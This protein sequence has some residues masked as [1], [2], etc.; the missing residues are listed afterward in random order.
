MNSLINNKDILY[1][2]FYN[3]P[4]DVNN[5]EFT[6]ISNDILDTIGDFILIIDMPNMG[7][8][9][10]FFMD[11]ITSYYKKNTIFVI[12]RNFNKM[13]HIYINNEYVLETKYNVEE[14]ILFLEKYKNKINKI[15]FDHIIHHNL[16]L[17]LHSVGIYVYRYICS[18]IDLCRVNTYVHICMCTHVNT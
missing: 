2:K 10:T 5:Y 15:L 7:G 1:T 14:S 3:N 4:I 13:L 16:L 18:C 6:T 17:A 11:V 12:A 9:V 8:G